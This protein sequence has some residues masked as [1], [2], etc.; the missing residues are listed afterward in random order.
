MGLLSFLSKNKQE[1]ASGEGEF[2]SRAEEESQVARGRKRRQG[3]SGKTNFST[4]SPVDPVL[5]EKKRA[6][7]RLVGAIALVLAMIIGLPMILD[8]EPKP[9]SEDIA[10]QIPSKD[11]QSI[12][13]AVVAPAGAS[14][15]GTS[16][17]LAASLGQ[18]EQVVQMPAPNS[19]ASVPTSATP[20][21]MPAPVAAPSASAS[22][23]V[24]AVAAKVKPQ[25][26]VK[27]QEKSVPVAAHDT[28]TKSSAKVEHVAAEKH[29][30][31]RAEAIL[32]GK[33]GDG[34]K[35]NAD[36][37]SAKFVVQVAA[38]AS[39]EKVNE[40]QGKLTEAG[41]KSYVQKVATDSGERIMRVR[42]GPFGSKDEAESARAKLSKMGLNGK[43]LP[44]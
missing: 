17:P 13:P 43:L 2:Y 7:R 23:P 25:E 5:P 33:D 15:S 4:N 41:I 29:D 39:Q 42:I 38:L 26:D 6:R 31:A 19:G 28:D 3:K 14:A 37:K 30:D 10:I 11:K 35:P 27:P 24:A 18:Q 9:V 8:S 44:S 36:K 40:L 21:R 34:G 12:P 20:V 1:T 22:S 16:V 32:E